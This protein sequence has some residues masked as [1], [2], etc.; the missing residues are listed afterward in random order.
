MK[1]E[2]LQRVRQVLD[3][4]N[5]KPEEFALKA[6]MKYTRLRNLLSGQGQPRLVDINAICS[7]FPEYSFWLVFDKVF[8]EVGQIN[9][10]IK[11]AQKQYVISP[12]SS[13]Q[14]ESK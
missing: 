14:D 8:P 2:F 6:G 4:E 7:A 5:M 12:E 13:E 1:E 9:P 3:Q 10:A 11:E